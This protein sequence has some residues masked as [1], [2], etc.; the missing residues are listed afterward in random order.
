MRHFHVIYEVTREYE[1]VVSVPASDCRAGGFPADAVL[2][3]RLADLAAAQRLP[4][5]AAKVAAKRIDEVDSGSRASS[6][7]RSA[8]EP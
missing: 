7:V 2:K 8:H 1:V 5:R 4:C 6:T 3:D